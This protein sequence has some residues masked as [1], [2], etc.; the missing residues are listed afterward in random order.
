MGIDAETERQIAAKIAEEVVGRPPT[1]GV[2]GVSGTGKSSTINAMFKVGLEVS[3]VVACT[4]E[5]LNVDL[6]APSSDP[7]L[8]GQQTVLRIVDAPGLGEDVRRDPEYLSMYEE[9]LPAADVIL[10]TM[11]AR[12]RAVAL[13]QQYLRHLAPFHDRMVF[14]INQIDLVEPRDWS[15]AANCP[16]RTQ[17]QNIDIIVQDRAERIESII[18]RKPVVV[19]Y[20]ATHLYGLQELFTAM[21]E[22]APPRRSWIFSAIKKFDPFDFI[23][24]QLRDRVA[25]DVGET[26]RRRMRW[27]R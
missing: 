10:W 23:P 8:A 22:A 9:A 21:V 25:Q 18:G 6:A 5:F 1:V 13:D 15:E 26:G 11:T 27:S 3:H 7:R 17:R 12:N 4:K 16:S 19:P 24:A 2:I 20:S 14:G